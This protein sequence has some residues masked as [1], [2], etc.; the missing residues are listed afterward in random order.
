MTK[1][2]RISPI[3]KL[4]GLQSFPVKKRRSPPRPAGRT[5]GGDQ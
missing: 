1:T 3:P 2:K 4:M 5:P